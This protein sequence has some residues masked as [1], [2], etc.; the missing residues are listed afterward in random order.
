[1]KASE[2]KE[3]ASVRNCCGLLERIREQANY[4]K[5]T[6]NTGINLV[7]SEVSALKTLGY[8]VEAVEDK[9]LECRV[10]SYNISW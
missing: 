3:I 10:A 4:G 7:E 8:T 5:F 2:A 6:L 9:R 1:M